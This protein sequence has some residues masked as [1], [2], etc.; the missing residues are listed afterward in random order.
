MNI[1]EQ[2]YEINFNKIY[3]YERKISID[4]KNTIIIGPPKSGKS[5]LIY[6]YLSHFKEE[7]YLYI[8]FKDY[9]ND[10]TFTKKDL[11]SFI[12]KNNIEVLVC[13]NFDFTIELP[14]NIES[15][16]I[17]TKIPKK[18][19]KFEHIYLDG[20]DF[21]EFLL[22]DIKHQNSSNSFNSFLKFGNFPEI[23][24]YSESKK[25]IRN[26]EICKLYCEDKMQQEILFLLIKNAGEKKSIFQ[27]FNSLKNEIKISKDRFYKT[28]A[29]FEENRVIF[30]CEKYEQPKAI[31]KIFVHNH[32]L[33]DIVSYKKN[34][35]NLFKN[36]VYIELN[37]RYKN[38]FYLDN[39]DFYLSNENEVI[40]AIPFFNSLI[41]STIISKL[42]PMIDIYNIEMITIVTVSSEQSLFIGDLEANITSFSSWAVSL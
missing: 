35:N 41:S 23:I 4:H 11:E 21:E 19:V 9:K 40:L 12:E 8:D 5:Y 3:F 15:T 28:C 18:L 27:L 1:L 25:Q 24:E 13:E 17:T 42:L 6:D 37:K 20:L 38:I 34:F 16:I 29:L 30:F 33:L 10:I 26:L 31:K 39:I 2:I 32:A 14:K 22:F 7:Q 36:M